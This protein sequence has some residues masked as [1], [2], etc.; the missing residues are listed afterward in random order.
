MKRKS[1]RNIIILVIIILL[2]VLYVLEFKNN[3]PLVK[4]DEGVIRRYKYD[5]Y[6]E[7]YGTKDV[8]DQEST[9]EGKDGELK[10][11]SLNTV[12]IMK[13][14]DN[15]PKEIKSEKEG[16]IVYKFV[17]NAEADKTYTYEIETKNGSWFFEYQK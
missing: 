9:G 14:T 4:S 7:Y 11:F 10:I 3:L 17:A 5:T 13:Y 15:K 16:L 6:A 2:I 1:N 12:R 8:K